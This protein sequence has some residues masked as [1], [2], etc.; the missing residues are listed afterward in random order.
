MSHKLVTD[1]FFYRDVSC[2]KNE[3]WVRVWLES[4]LKNV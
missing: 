4:F 1:V 3:H 2:V